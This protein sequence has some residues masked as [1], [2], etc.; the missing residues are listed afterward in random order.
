MKESQ[1][2]YASRENDDDV[3]CCMIRWIGWDVELYRNEH[4]IS[5]EGHNDSFADETAHKKVKIEPLG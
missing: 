4:E 2:F 3:F 5:L 1:E